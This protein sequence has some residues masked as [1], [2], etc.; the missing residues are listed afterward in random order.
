MV[1]YNGEYKLETSENFDEYMKA[2]G[3]GMLTRK[4][5]ASATPVLTVT[6]DGDHWKIKQVT[7]FKTHEEEFTIGVEQEKSTPDGRKVKSIVTKEGDKIID[8]QVGDKTSIII[9]EFSDAGI[10]SIATVDNISCKRFYKRQ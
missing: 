5:A 3:V 7:S 9:R 2:V 4:A 6:V 1:A 8:K 10:T